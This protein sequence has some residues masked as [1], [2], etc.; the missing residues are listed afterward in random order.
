[1]QL[2]LQLA[3]HNVQ[4]IYKKDPRN[5]H[6]NALLRLR[7]MADTT[8]EDWDELPSFLPSKQFAEHTEVNHMADAAVPPKL[9]H[10]HNRR[11]IQLLHDH[12]ATGN[13]TFLDD[14]AP[15]KLFTTVQPLRPLTPGLNP[16]RTKK[17][18]LRSS[19][20]LFG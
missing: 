1:M 8:A 19:A 3:E 11:D 18:L 9:R 17:R 14:M 16:S 7:T 5:V 12:D 4:V 10:K 20:I 6:A 13:L 15:E 2:C